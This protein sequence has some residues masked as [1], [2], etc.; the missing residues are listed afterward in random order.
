MKKVSKFWA[1][2]AMCFLPTYG[3]CQSKSNDAIIAGD[4]VAVTSTDNGQVRGYIHN[5]M[6]NYKGIPYAQAKRFMPPEKPASWQGVRA[7]LV[8]GA[9]CPIDATTTVIDPIEFAFQH[10]WGYMNED[11]QKLNIWTPGIN[12]QKKRPVMVWLHGGGFSAGSAIELPSYDGENLS[13]KGDVVVVSINHRLNA[14]GFLN[15][16]AYGDKYKASA[17]VGMMDIVAALQWV[18][19]N[20]ASFGGDPDNV[21]IF[22]QSGGG[23]KVGTLMNAPSAKGLFQKA[24]IESGSYRSDFMTADVSKRIGAAVMEVLNL[25]PAQVDSLQTMSYERLSAACK[26]AFAKVQQQLKTEGKAVGAF[27]LMWEPSVDGSFLPYN[28]TDPAAIELSKN[29]P[30]LVGSTKTE[31]MASMINPAIRKFTMDEAKAY[32]QKKYGDKT[33][34][35]IAEVNKAYPNTVKPSDYID[36]D[37]TT[38]RPGV[39]RQANAKSAVA[40]AAPVYMYQFAWQSPVMD[41][42]YK[43]IHC[44]DIP[45]EFDNIKRCEEMTGGGKEAYA[46]AAKMSQAWIN[47]ARTGNPNAK[48]LPSWPAYTQQNGAAMLFDNQSVVKQ[49]NDKVLLEMAATAK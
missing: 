28:M 8:Y 45:F 29:I 47:F 22:G 37:L 49:N 34:A 31:F 12:D 19:Q 41:G 33:D 38:F 20:I 2:L 4:D 35:Y 26:K 39:V 5:G 9:V 21:T 6:F 46:L 42:M 44:I 24:I 11:C 18:K 14:L 15:L 7:S 25:Q 16:S 17:N 13:K 32:L 40:G 27:G 36:I 3:F 10:N 23:A 30:L 1:V 43:S 48:G